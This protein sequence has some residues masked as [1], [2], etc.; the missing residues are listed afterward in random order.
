MI[1]RRPFSVAI[2]APLSCSTFSIFV[3]S[4]LMVLPKG[5]LTP[6][7]A[8]MLD[9]SSSVN[10]K[11]IILAAELSSLPF[12]Y[13]NTDWNHNHLSFSSNDLHTSRKIIIKRSFLLFLVLGLLLLSFSSSM[14]MKVFVSTH[15]HLSMLFTAFENIMFFPHAKA[16][17]EH[18]A[19]NCC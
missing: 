9:L 2:Y 11:F 19:Q 7:S 6:M 10:F 12:T 14:F 1:F 15:L 18:F 8:T 3:L 16:S 17:L 5:L 13:I 4:H